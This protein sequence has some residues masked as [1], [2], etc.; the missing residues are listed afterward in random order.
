MRCQL[1]KNDS[2]IC[3]ECRKSTP[4]D[5]LAFQFEKS[6]GGLMVD[7]QPSDDPKGHFKTYLEMISCRPDDRHKYT[8]Q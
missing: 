1:I 7:P 6:I 5:C 3:D 2:E 8:P 4:K